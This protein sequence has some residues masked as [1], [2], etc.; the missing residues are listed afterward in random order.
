[1]RKRRVPLRKCVSCGEK[2]A[3]QELIRIVKTTEGDFILD[4]S[5]RINGRGAYICPSVGCFEKGIESKRLSKAFRE[6]VPKEVL[7]TLKI[8]IEEFIKGV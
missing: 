8:E 4:P 1:M 6:E 2:R 3:K 7:D 5:G